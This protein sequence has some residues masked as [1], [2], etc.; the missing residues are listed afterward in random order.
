MAKKSLE[1]GTLLVKCWKCEKDS[2]VNVPLGSIAVGPDGGEV[3]IESDPPTHRLGSKG[4]RTFQ[5]Q[6]QNKDCLGGPGSTGTLNTVDFKVGEVMLSEY[7][8]PAET[9]VAA[10]A[11]GA[12]TKVGQV[13]GRQP[14]PYLKEDVDLQRGSEY[15]A[16]IINAL[17]G[18]ESFRFNGNVPNQNLI[19]NLPAGV[20]VEV[21][22]IVDNKGLHPIR[23]GD[24][25]LP[26]ATLTIINVMVEE[27]AVE[28]ALAGDPSGV[29]HAIAYDPLT[30]AVLS[31]AETRNMVND[32]L[33]QN[34]QY[35]PQFHHYSV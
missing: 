34:K 19:T 31:L 1:K 12:Q 2:P 15:A 24:L 35:L 7:Q 14:T 13:K 23:I 26:C 4:G 11:R 33:V 22:V 17:A 10:A 6:C 28:A 9:P 8:T 3:K 27:M 20:C 18:G 5:V 29:F 30:A 21:P 16:Y 25:P 32:M